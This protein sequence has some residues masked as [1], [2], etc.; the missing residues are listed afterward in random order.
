MRKKNEHGGGRLSNKEMMRVERKAA[1]GQRVKKEIRRNTVFS[2]TNQENRSL[3]KIKEQNVGILKCDVVD[4][5][6]L[7]IL[8]FKSQS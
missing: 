3:R 5:V 1:R 6:S 2:G 7:F 8:L 4:C